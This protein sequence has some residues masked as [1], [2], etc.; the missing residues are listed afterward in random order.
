MGSRFVAAD[1]HPDHDTLN[2]F[3]KRFLKAIEGLMI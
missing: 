2:T 1:E 3:R